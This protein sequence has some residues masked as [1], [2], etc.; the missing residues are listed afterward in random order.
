MINKPY[1]F[2]SSDYDKILFCSDTHYNHNPKWDIP[3]WKMRGFNSVESH[4]R[5]QE[6]EFSKV[7]ENSIIFHLG[8]PALNSTPE[9]MLNLFNKTS[10]KIFFIFGNHFS[11]DYALYRSAMNLYLYERGLT[12][13]EKLKIDSPLQYEIFPFS[14]SRFPENNVGQYKIE[15]YNPSYFVKGNPGLPDKNDKHTLTYL[16]IQ[17][18]IQIDKNLF[19]LSHMAPKI[20]YYMGDNGIA[21]VGH[22]HGSCKGLNP[23]DNEGKVLDC[24]IENSI[25]YNNSAFFS[26]EDIL[27]IMKKKD[28]LIVDHH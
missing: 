28:R 21:L 27:T 26:L 18:N 2:K 13:N 5:W 8:D 14:I 7:S 6:N 19:Q 23:F 24:G 4:D 9:K 12:E 1:K 22:S 20:W 3:L 16:G 25:S 11:C 17:C 15:G 10:S